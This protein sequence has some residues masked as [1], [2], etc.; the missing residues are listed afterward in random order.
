MSDWEGTLFTLSYSV[1][2][3]NQIFI[4]SYFGT[5]LTIKS[6]ELTYSLFKSNWVTQDMNFKKAMIILT[7]KARKP[8]VIIVGGLFTLNLSTFLSVSVRTV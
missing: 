3:M 5:L 2:M 4:P 6:N 8:I 1:C 7:E